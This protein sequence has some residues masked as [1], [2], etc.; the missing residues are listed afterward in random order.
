MTKEQDFTTEADLVAAFVAHVEGWNAN[1]NRKT[2][3]WTVYPETAGWDLLL[4]D[5]GGVARLCLT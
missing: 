2:A 4:V 3:K 1:P 5:E